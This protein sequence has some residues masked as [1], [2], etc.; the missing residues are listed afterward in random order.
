[1]R[2]ASSP[3]IHHDAE[4]KTGGLSDITNMIQRKGSIK[5][6]IA[7]T[8]NALPKPAVARPTVAQPRSKSNRLEE[9]NDHEKKSEKPTPRRQIR[10][11]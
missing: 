10:M 6:D 8:S 9:V 11:R 1:M 3:A 2:R 7:E 4:N 5:S